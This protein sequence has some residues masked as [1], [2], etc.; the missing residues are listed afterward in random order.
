MRVTARNSLGIAAAVLLAT[1]CG[2]TYQPETASVTLDAGTVIQVAPLT[3]LSPVTEKAGDSFTATLAAPLMKGEQVIVPEGTTVLGEVVDAKA[4]GPGE[5]GSSFLSLELKEIVAR[6][7]QSVEV[8]TE[9]VRYAPVQ[10]AE[11]GQQPE[12]SEQPQAGQQPEESGSVAAPPV[13]TQDT[14]VA[15]RL[16]EPVDVPVTMSPEGPSTPIS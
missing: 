14:T 2:K 3:T 8:K 12:A 11:S 15:F 5:E 13:V 1:A 16:A 4:G 6:G 7:G 10:Q 9:P